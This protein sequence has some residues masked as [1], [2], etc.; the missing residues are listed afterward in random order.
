MMRR[1]GLGMVVA[2]LLALVGCDAATRTCSN[3]GLCVDCSSVCTKMVTCR[4][5]FESGATFGAQD[6]Q[7]RC[8]RGCAT[9]DTITPERARCID[10]VD[11]TNVNRCHREIVGCLGVDAGNIYAP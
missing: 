6:E 7:S 8:E 4:V 11:T 9:S 2:G 10:A 5:G 1:A 3:A